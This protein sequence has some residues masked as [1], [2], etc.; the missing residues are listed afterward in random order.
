MKRKF[1][2][3][4][5]LMLLANTVFG[6]ASG[7][8]L[9]KIGGKITND[10]F[11]NGGLKDYGTNAL[12]AIDAMN[13][14]G[15]E[16]GTGDKFYVDSGTPGAGTGTSWSTAVATLQA[17]I[18]L[19]AA[20][21][22][23]II[24]VAAGHAESGSDPCLWDA[25]CNGIT[26]MHLGNRDQQ[27]TYTF[28]DTDTTVI[29]SVADVTIIGGRLLAGI[30]EVVVGL[31]VPANGKRLTVIGMEWPEPGTS[32][33]EFNIG[34]QLT[35]DSNDAT[36]IG[37]TAYSADAVGA[38]HWL[39]GGAGIVHRL[40]L[41]DNLIVGEFAIAPIFSDQA[42]I[43]CN[44][45]HNKVVNM[46]TGQHGIEFSGNATGFCNDNLVITDAIGNSYD[47]GLMDGGGGLWGDEDSSDT[48]PVPWTTN[49]T[50]VN[51]WGVT[52]LAQI[53]AEALDAVSGVTLPASPT[54][55][56]LAA[57]IASGGTAL[58]TELGDSVSLVDA[59][60]SDGA[61]LIDVA[62]GLAGI[63]GIPTD[64]D[65]AVD[66]TN[67]AAN[68]DGSLY[69]RLESIANEVDGTTTVA[70]RTYATQITGV[71]IADKDLFLV[72]NGP[73][74]ITSFVGE[75]T[76]AIAATACT[77]KIWMDA[78]EAGLDYDFSTAVDMTGAVDGGRIIFTNVNPSVL[79]P[80]ALGATGAG[81]LMSSWYCTP[82]MI[83]TV[84]TDDLTPN[85]NITWS[86]TWIPIVD[87]V[88]VTAQ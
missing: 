40:T 1:V 41:I 75:V 53:E 31:S 55:D 7:Y 57:F 87:G 82:G 61:A 5:L 63:I 52:E 62:V 74:M 86:M 12:R 88:T 34:V 39:N 84:D 25:D 22:G 30:S 18:D 64:A 77:T 43:E 38:D 35:T 23:D 9:G 24:Y 29:V 42:D 6:G 48:T 16:L 80:L 44:I 68:A 15:T 32:T 17:G 14:E 26:I 2:F 58:G 50:G 81:S 49:E 56:S 8:P 13:L 73:I 33:F 54:T 65:N 70:G 83:E 67:I 3:I 76:T 11:N 79:T 46:T 69:E 72:A 19:C 21:N 27:G 45:E 28:A 10:W 4:M 66:S 60:G 51:R 36:F 20:N 37:C 47:T 85:G 59:L 78:T 71:I